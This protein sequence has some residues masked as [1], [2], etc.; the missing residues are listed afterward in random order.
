MQIS[1]FGTGY[2]G[3]V[4]G[5]CFA[6]MGNDVI[7]ADVDAGK[8]AKLKD[9]IS[10]IYEPGLD[11]LIANNIHAK[12]INFTTD[13]KD[14][15]EKSD[16]LFIAVGT[17][18]D[19]DGSADLKYV[20]SVAETIRSPHER[21]QTDR[22][23]IDS[24]RRHLPESQRTHATDFQKRG[25]SFA[26]DVASNPEF[27]REGSAIEDCLKPNRVVVGTESENAVATLKRIYD[28]FLKNGNPYLVM[29]P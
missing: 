13:L 21:L 16:I 8:I 4:T 6:E 28:P 22:H 15:V 29:D 7:C 5:V 27:L 14:A 26:F 23:Q 20:L 17:P 25:Q 10:P 1:V 11:D 12:R 2:V 24:S 9:G 18:S 19:V 3:L